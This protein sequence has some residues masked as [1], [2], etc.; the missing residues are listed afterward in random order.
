VGRSED[1][2]T[3][4]D[5]GV[6]RARWRSSGARIRLGSIGWAR[7]SRLSTLTLENAAIRC[8]FAVSR[9]T[10]II[11]FVDKSLD[12]DWV[13]Y[14]GRGPVAGFAGLAPPPFGSFLDGYSGGWQLVLPN[15]GVP[16]EYRG[17]ALGQHAEAAV[18]EWDARIL[19]DDPESVAVWFGVELVR[20]PLT[21]ERVVELDARGSGITVTETVRNTGGVPIEIMWGEH[22]AFGAGVL[23]GGVSIRLPESARVVL[24]Q[25]GGEVPHFER[26]DPAERAASMSYL[27]LD[28]GWYE[29]RRERGG[30]LR[31]EW[32]AAVQ[33][34]L[35]V[36]REFASTPGHPFWAKHV[37]LG[38]EPFA[39][40]PT[41]GLARAV[42]NGTA[43]EL[44]A[45]ATAAMTWAVTL[46]GIDPDAEE[47]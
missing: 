22:L 32:D 36:W 45:G 9:G 38:L 46:A 42:E 24:G 2:A 29:V 23:D 7:S 10:D 8:T 43:L 41:H 27:E 5:R 3:H 25:G 40:M 15:G 19:R 44:A 4:A 21:V 12:L 37:A 33:P 35:W 6:V 26:I 13:S 34:Y 31:V 14:D 11:E 18:L 28:E 16:V 17:A 20:V 1:A 30:A 47:A 39:G